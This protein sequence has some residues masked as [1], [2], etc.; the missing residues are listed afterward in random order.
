MAPAIHTL[1]DIKNLG[2]REVS[3][4]TSVKGGE[5]LENK[6]ESWFRMRWLILLQLGNGALFLITLYFGQRWCLILLSA[7]GWDFGESRDEWTPGVNLENTF[8]PWA[9]R[10][11][12]SF[13]VPRG[14]YCWVSWYPEVN[15]ADF[16]GKYCWFQGW[17]RGDPGGVRD[18]ELALEGALSQGSESFPSWTATAA[19]VLKKNNK[20]G[21]ACLLPSSPSTWAR[22]LLETSI[23]VWP[24]EFFCEMLLNYLA[25]GGFLHCEL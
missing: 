9:C 14:K 5:V 18:G 8:I 24:A 23:L 19:V 15:I 10:V 20:N 16:R 7:H 11:L 6:A 3:L 2:N 13:P 12:L 21:S 22:T 25:L 4:F 17:L 1:P